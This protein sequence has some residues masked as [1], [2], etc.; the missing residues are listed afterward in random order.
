MILREFGLI[1]FPLSHSFSKNYFEEKFKKEGIDDAEYHLFEIQEIN[2][3]KDLARKRPL[4]DGLNVTIPYKEQ[5]IALLNAIDPVAADICAVNCI[6][7]TRYY[8]EP[9][10]KGYNTDMQAFME[11]IRPHLKSHHRQALVLGTGGAAKAV[12]YGLQRDGISSQPVSRKPEEGALTYTELE[13]EDLSE[14]QIIINATPVGMFPNI[15][16]CPEISFEKIGKN[17]LLVD[18]IYNPGET[19]FLKK[20]KNCGATMLNG[21]KMLQLQAELSWNIWNYLG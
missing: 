2:Q 14:Y 11:M 5:V 10:L 17:H 18:L 3:V 13:K 16:S 15:E 1:G 20:G 8:S 21:M 4:L 7:V 6:A 12:I 9:F 19:L